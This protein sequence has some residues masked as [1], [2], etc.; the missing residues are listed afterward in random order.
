MSCKLAIEDL[1]LYYG[2]F[3]ALKSINM[4]IQPNEITAFIGPSGCGNALPAKIQM[5]R[6]SGALILLN[7]FDSLGNIVECRYIKK[8]NFTLVYASRK[9]RINWK[10]CII[11]NFKFVKD[12]FKLPQ[13]F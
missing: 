2:D 5:H 12:S 11:R 13:K 4:E 10:L 8:F 6:K 9:V 7:L 3:H 1:N